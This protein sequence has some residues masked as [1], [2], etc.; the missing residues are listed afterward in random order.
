[1]DISQRLQTASGFQW[2]AGNAEKNWRS[3]PVRTSECEQVF[4]NQPLIV[5]ADVA[6]SAEEERFFVLG[7][8]DAG[9]ELFLVF[10]L[11]GDLI[12]VISARDMSRNER[13]VYRS[14][15]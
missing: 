12:R 14:H 11:R 15:A 10:T 3:H 5:A 8:S 6:H 13:K 1:M 4:F 2:D 7:Q 9:R